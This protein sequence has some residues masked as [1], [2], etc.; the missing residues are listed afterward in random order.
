VTSDHHPLLP[1]QS[2]TLPANIRY[3]HLHR[4]SV[5][6]VVADSAPLY[7]TYLPSDS[8][9]IDAEFDCAVKQGNWKIRIAT[10][11]HTTEE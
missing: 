2:I 9:C 6:V 7:M 4:R 10:D 11:P 1:P 8:N 3:T 5:I